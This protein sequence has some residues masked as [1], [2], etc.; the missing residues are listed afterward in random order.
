MEF[1]WQTQAAIYACKHQWMDRIQMCRQTAFGNQ[2][3]A[4]S[5][6]ALAST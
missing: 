3:F 4:F 5:S 2:C 1:F 6:L